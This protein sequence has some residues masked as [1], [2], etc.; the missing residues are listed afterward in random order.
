MKKGA[1]FVT[2]MFIES[3]TYFM[4]GKISSDQI[5]EPAV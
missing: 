4:Q 3:K 2:N 1:F 5:P